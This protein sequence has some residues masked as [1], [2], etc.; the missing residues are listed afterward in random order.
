MAFIL[1]VLGK[2]VMIRSPSAVNTSPNAVVKRPARRAPGYR[3]PT[4][5]LRSTDLVG[6]DVRLNI[7]EHLAATLGSR[8]E[9]PAL[10]R[11]KV[12]RGDKAGQGFY[13]WDD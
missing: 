13:H 7:A 6:L 9:P 10:L 5:P 11:E 4:G 2:V 12:A 1:G 8:F 3:H